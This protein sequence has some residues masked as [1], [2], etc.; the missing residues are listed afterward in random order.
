MRPI[1]NLSAIVCLMLSLGCSGD[2]GDMP[3]VGAVHGSV[4]LNGEPV[5]N[6]AVKFY[7]LEGGRTST[8][9]TDEA[10]MYTLTY[11]A[12]VDGAKVGMHEVAVSTFEAASGDGGEGASA[13][14]K[15]IVPPKY[16][17]FPS[18]LKVEVKAGDNELALDVSP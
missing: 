7:P 2:V 13:G 10:G 9:V 5:S 1:L 18:Q 17:K 16:S 14:R 6:A 11:N 4:T 12:T 15:E 3:E 8:A